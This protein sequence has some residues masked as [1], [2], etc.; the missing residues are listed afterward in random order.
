MAEFRI[1]R[2]D[3]LSFK[4]CE[5]GVVIF[6]QIALDQNHGESDI[7]LLDGWTE[8]H[9]IFMY[10]LYPV[11]HKWLMEKKL[12][13]RD[14]VASMFPPVAYQKFYVNYPDNSFVHHP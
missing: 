4:A 11:F 2:S 3:I 7:I 1:K 6:D 12:I 13:P 8:L 10:Q 5:A 9:S 14:Y